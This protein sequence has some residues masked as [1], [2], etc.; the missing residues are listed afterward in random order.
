LN[1]RWAS[2]IVIVIEP[3]MGQCNCNCNLIVDEQN[4]IGTCLVLSTLQTH[5]VIYSN[6]HMQS[7]T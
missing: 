1:Q 2:V 3:E 5:S 4:V 7:K 6:V